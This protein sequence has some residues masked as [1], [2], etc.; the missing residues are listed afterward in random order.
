M[1]NI[2]LLL[3]KVEEETIR[4]RLHPLRTCADFLISMLN[5]ALDAAKCETGDID[6][7]VNQ[8]EL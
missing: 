3:E 4:E 1:G 6:I 2:D 7:V 8:V 5:N